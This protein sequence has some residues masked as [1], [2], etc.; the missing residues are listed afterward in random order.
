MSKYKV[1]DKVII[2]IDDV[3]LGSTAENNPTALYRIKG[4]NSL[5]FDKNGLDKLEKI[6]TS[7]AKDWSET[8]EVMEREYN[9]GLND[10]W[11]LARD[12]YKMQR[13]LLLDVFGACNINTLFKRTPQELVEKLKVYEES[14][15]V[16]VGDVVRFK[17]SKTELLITSVK[18]ELNGIHIQTDEYGKF[19]DVHSCICRKDVEKTGK[20]LDIEHLLEQ[21][22]GNE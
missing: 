13:D 18:D 12:I 4:F 11:K 15:V 2:E 20:H 5:V 9:R 16:K 6:P 3:M 19:G 7:D 10:A 14:K 22:R 21:I 17:D 1:G 8:I